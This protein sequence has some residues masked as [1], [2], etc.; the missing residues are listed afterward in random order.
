MEP[1]DARK[2]FP[3]FDE[4]QLKANFSLQMVHKPEY[5]VLFNT[6]LK[7]SK[8]YKG[9]SDLLLDTFE[10]TVSMSTYLVAFVV[11]DFVSISNTTSKGTKVG[12]LPDPSNSKL[13]FH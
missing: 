2:A 6:P 5:D 4:P 13:D 3:C 10:T 1:V 7:T 11:S 9:S 8:P 12:F